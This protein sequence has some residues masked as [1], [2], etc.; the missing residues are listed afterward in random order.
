MTAAAAGAEELR[1]SLR[2]DTGLG[3]G[4]FYGL[5]VYLSRVAFLILFRV[6]LYHMERVPPKGRTIIASS[7][8]SV[9]D[10]WLLGAVFDRTSCYL[11][12][13]SLFRV[14]LLGWLIRM[15]DAF[16]IPRESVASRRAIQTCVD[17]LRRDRA[18]FLFPEGHRSEDGRLQPLKRGVALIARRADAVILPVLLLGTGSCWPLGRLLPRPGSVKIYF[19]EPIRMETNETSDSLI[20]R[21]TDCYTKLAREA[22]AVDVL[23]DEFLVGEGLKRGKEPLPSPQNPGK[24]T[25]P[26]QSA[27]D[28]S[29][30]ACT[31]PSHRSGLCP[32]GA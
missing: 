18:L 23:S 5:A 21:L 12:K 16:P 27:G 4:F 29:L 14:P 11:A 32:S 28:D 19:A 25:Y 15:F 9:L 1:F 26:P 22:G 13:D 24:G 17:I 8:Q 3:R 30:V 6:R 7:H 10:P 20:R 31:T 2:R